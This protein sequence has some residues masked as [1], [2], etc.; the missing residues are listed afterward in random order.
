MDEKEYY[1]E[2]GKIR[3]SRLNKIISAVNA[4]VPEEKIGLV[5]EVGKWFYDSL[6]TQANEHVGKYGFWPVFDLCEIET[7]DPILDIYKD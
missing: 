2:L 3:G 7:D 4:K 1:S 5:S 6:I